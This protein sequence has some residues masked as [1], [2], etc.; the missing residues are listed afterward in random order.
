MAEVAPSQQEGAVDSWIRSVPMADQILGRQLLAAK[1]SAAAWARGWTTLSAAA[2]GCGLSEGTYSAVVSNDDGT[3]RPQDETLA[4]LAATLDLDREELAR[5]RMGVVSVTGD[6]ELDELIE[7]IRGLPSEQRSPVY[8]L[9][10]LPPQQS[11]LIS[12]FVR[13][14]TRAISTAP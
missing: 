12:N 7:T 4:K 13:E 6:P 10:A 3:Y 5:L 11:S 8:F 9:A 2:A 1:V 14:L